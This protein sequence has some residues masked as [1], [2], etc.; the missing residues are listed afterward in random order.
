M[1]KKYDV[2][3]L[4][5]LI[6]SLPDFADSFLNIRT[7]SGSI[8]NFVFNRAQQYLHQRLEAQRESTGKVRALVL[9]GRQQGISTYIQARYFHKVCTQRG[10]RAFIL[11]HQADATKNLFDMTRRYYDSLPAGLVPKPDASSAKELTFNSLNS[12]YKVGTAGNQSVGRS[13]T[14][15]LLHASEVAYYQH[16]DE[17]S[18]GILQTVSNEDDTEIIMESTANGIGNYF[19]D[20]W[21]SAT[22]GQ[23]EFQAIFI[24]W[25]WQNEYTTPLLHL[26]SPNLTDDEQELFD[27]H[28]KNGLT[29]EHLY[30][31]RRK[32]SEFSNDYDTA[33]E[34]FNVEYPPTAMEAFRNP[35]ADCFIKPA[36]VNRARK[37]NIESDSPLILGVD[38]ARSGTDASAI[39]RRRGRLVYDPEQHY[40]L[41][42]ME[43][44]GVV[45]RIIDKER[46]TKVCI[47]VI[48]IGAGVVD[49]LIELGY[50]M[51]EGVNSARHANLRYEFVNLRA[52]MWHT[53]REWLAQDAPV[54]LPDSDTLAGELCCLGY[55]F[56]SSGRLQIESK[57]DLK[58][59]GMRSPDIADALCLTYIVGDYLSESSYSHKYIP[60]KAQG[61]FI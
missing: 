52:E 12:G 8:Q 19:Y 61:M 33:I 1:S 9:K 44:V 32:L 20:M 13:Q 53:M 40:K 60:D 6:K 7:K 50:T 11:T 3:N 59:R 46:P 2:D 14:I 5:T 38:P 43:L 10:K 26:E 29:I 37:Q 36:L 56:D 24:P 17:H 15:Q 49:R 28:N 35:I 16:A 23:S 34:R 57:D 25:Y 22:Q 55:K 4:V 27:T 39:I 31:R 47:D 21:M 42:T 45:K 48:G 54:Q 58:K 30:W 51:V 18:K 41:N